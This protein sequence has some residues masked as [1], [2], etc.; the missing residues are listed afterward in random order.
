MAGWGGVEISDGK[1]PEGQW[2]REGE[3]PHS[4]SVLS[5]LKGRPGPPHPPVKPTGPAN[6]TVSFIWLHKDLK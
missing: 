1:P 3:E 4:A 5:R 2:R 6:S